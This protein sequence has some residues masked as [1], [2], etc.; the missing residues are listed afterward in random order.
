[1][2]SL[3]SRTILGVTMK[4]LHQRVE[5]LAPILAQRK[6]SAS[7]KARTPGHTPFIKVQ[8][9][10]LRDSSQTSFAWTRDNLFY[11]ETTTHLEHSYFQSSTE[12]AKGKHT[13]RAKRTSGN[14]LS[15]SSSYF[16]TTRKGLTLSHLTIA[17]SS[18]SLNFC[19]SKS[20]LKSK[21]QC[22]S[23]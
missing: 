21:R 14:G 2:A 11:G 16:Y 23:N 5:E 9:S 7:K 17:L 6:S 22:R 10:K 12:C 3:C 13:V 1:M 20:T 4:I 18:L 8:Y 15:E 19:T